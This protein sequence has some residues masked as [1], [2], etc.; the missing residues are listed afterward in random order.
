MLSAQS[1]GQRVMGTFRVMALLNQTDSNW[2]IRL[3]GLLIAKSYNGK[4]SV[5]DLAL[6]GNDGCQSK[7]RPQH[8]HCDRLQAHTY[9]YVQTNLKPNAQLCPSPLSSWEVEFGGPRFG[10]FWSFWWKWVALNLGGS[11]HC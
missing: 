5:S 8:Q 7:A 10:K 1:L 4:T 9:M 11:M 2:A 6:L 3:R